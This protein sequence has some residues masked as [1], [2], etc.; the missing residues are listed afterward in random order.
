MHQEKANR[1]FF[2]FVEGETYVKMKKLRNKK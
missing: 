2:G 1:C